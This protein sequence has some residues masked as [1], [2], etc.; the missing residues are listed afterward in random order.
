MEEQLL[1]VEQV[2]VTNQQERAGGGSEDQHQVTL[3]TGEVTSAGPP[4]L[5]F[6]HTQLFH[7]INSFSTERVNT[8]ERQSA[9]TCTDRLD[10]AG[11]GVHFVC[12]F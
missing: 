5:E 2:A 8:S 11:F 3:A 1:D 6:F 4:T 9:P 12:H 7:R 10:Y